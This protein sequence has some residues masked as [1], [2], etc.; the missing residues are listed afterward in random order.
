MHLFAVPDLLATTQQVQRSDTHDVLVVIELDQASFDLLD[1][2]THRAPECH[3]AGIADI[4]TDSNARL[5][6]GTS[7]GSQLVATHQSDRASNSC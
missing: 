2:G 4:Q 5:R 1:L 7:G 6:H 3:A